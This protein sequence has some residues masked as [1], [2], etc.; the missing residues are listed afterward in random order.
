MTFDSVLSNVCLLCMPARG[1]AVGSGREWGGMFYWASPHPQSTLPRHENSRGRAAARKEQRRVDLLPVSSGAEQS[2]AR[3]HGWHWGTGAV[4]QWVGLG[5][6]G[7]RSRFSSVGKGPS[8]PRSPFRVMFMGAVLTCCICPA[9][10]LVC[11]LS[12]P[13]LPKRW[14]GEWIM[15]KKTCFPQFSCGGRALGQALM[16][17][18]CKRVN[19]ACVPAWQGLQS[20]PGRAGCKCFST[21]S[22]A[23]S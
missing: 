14:T 17:P 8:P 15:L 20:S 10:R 2:G 4:A 22:R 7:H 3:V 21:V 23:L 9:P 5:T 6:G 18:C 13:V 1:G 19:C 11:P 12:A 16:Q